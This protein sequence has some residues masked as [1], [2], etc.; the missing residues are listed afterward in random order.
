MTLTEGQQTGG[1]VMLSLKGLLKIHINK[2][3]GLSRTKIQLCDSEVHLMQKVSKKFLR[4]REQH[5][6]IT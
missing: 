2:K 3:R 1:S 6:Y 4:S 5:I